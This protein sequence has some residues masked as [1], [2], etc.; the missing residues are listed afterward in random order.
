MND[1]H[2]DFDEYFVVSDLHK[3]EWADVRKVAIGLQI[4]DDE[5]K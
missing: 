1:E 3:R 5:K 4:V 2:M